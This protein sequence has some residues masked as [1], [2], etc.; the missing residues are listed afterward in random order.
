MMGLE[1]AG[2]SAELAELFH[3]DWSQWQNLGV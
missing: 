3:A 1:H 2:G